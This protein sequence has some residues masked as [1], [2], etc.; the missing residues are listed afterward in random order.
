MPKISE[1]AEGMFPTSRGATCT[2]RRVYETHP[3]GK[4]KQQKHQLSRTKRPHSLRDFESVNATS[5]CQWRDT[6]PAPT[7]LVE[8]LLSRG[9]VRVSEGGIVRHRQNSAGAWKAGCVCAELLD[10]LEPT[11]GESGRGKKGGWRVIGKRTCTERTRIS[12]S[13]KAGRQAPFDLIPLGSTWV[14]VRSRPGW[15]LNST[16][17]DCTHRPSRY[18]SSSSADATPK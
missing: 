7:D 14:I 12:R 2:G 15:L 4:I 1:N 13:E 9:Q 16:Q 10:H 3:T 5:P 17:Q 8:T 6:N 11:R 18:C